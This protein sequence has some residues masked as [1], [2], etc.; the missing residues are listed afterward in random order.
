[1][2]AGGG[3]SGGIS[4]TIAGGDFWQG[5]RK[6][7]ITSLNYMKIEAGTA[8]LGFPG[9]SVELFNSSIRKMRITHT[10]N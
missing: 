3:L 2:I 9:S 8:N 1:M 6:G 10:F 4:S 7:L 5:M